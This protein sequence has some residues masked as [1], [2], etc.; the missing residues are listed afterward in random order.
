MRA[1]AGVGAT[2][3][4][5]VVLAGCG[6]QAPVPQPKHTVKAADTGQANLLSRAKYR[7]THDFHDP[8]SAQFR[9][10]SIFHVGG[11]LNVCGEANGK[12][13]DGAYVGFEPFAYD[14]ALDRGMIFSEGTADSYQTF[15]AA[16]CRNVS[17]AQVDQENR[18]AEAAENAK[19]HETPLPAG[20]RTIGVV[21]YAETAVDPMAQE[22]VERLS[23]SGKLY[24]EVENSRVALL[25]RKSIAEPG[26]YLV[27]ATG[28]RD[29]CHACEG[30][31][32]LYFWH[33]EGAEPESL[34][35]I[36]PPKT[37]GSWGNAPEVTLYR[38]ANHDS[39]TQ[40][41]RL[42]TEITG[43]GCS[44]KEGQL[45]KVDSLTVLPVADP[46]SVDEGCPGA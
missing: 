28:N 39:F 21:P 23:D 32:Q 17:Q 11:R 29:E 2:A 42:S 45:F 25:P 27:V 19:H 36:G 44:E 14:S 38:S 10:I 24:A 1:L 16:I 6:R 46:Y 13:L 7:V 20:Y 3:L 40:Y 30:V 9:E 15:S 37:G 5:M 18:A 33:K 41:M 34:N 43:Q 31:V 8:S 22:A 12:N 26:G 35:E 4:A